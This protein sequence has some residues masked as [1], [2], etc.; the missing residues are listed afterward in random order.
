MVSL[1]ERIPDLH[2]QPVGCRVMGRH[3]QRLS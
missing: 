1:V 2:R 3:L